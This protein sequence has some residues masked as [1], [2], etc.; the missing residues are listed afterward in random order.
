MK[1]PLNW[2]SIPRPLSFLIHYLCFLKYF[3]IPQMF[4][5]LGND[6]HV[7]CRCAVLF[8][9]ILHEKYVIYMPTSYV[10]YPRNKL[11]RM[12]HFFSFRM[13]TFRPGYSTRITNF[14]VQLFASLS[15]KIHSI[16]AASQSIVGW[17]YN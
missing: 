12:H 3:M 7:I 14:E 6:G 16:I 11:M 15:S 17:F 8:C 9:T 1:F 10:E 2:R 13:N 4:L 5:S